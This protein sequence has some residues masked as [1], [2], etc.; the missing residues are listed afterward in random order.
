MAL[1]SAIKLNIKNHLSHRV[2]ADLPLEVSDEY[3]DEAT[4][5]WSQP[6]GKVSICPLPMCS[7]YLRSI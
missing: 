4:R 3:Y 2:D 5:R 1:E 7:A 6:P